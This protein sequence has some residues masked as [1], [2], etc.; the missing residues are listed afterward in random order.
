MDDNTEEHPTQEPQSN[1]EPSEEPEKKSGFKLNISG[2]KSAYKV[3]NGGWWEQVGCSFRK[4]I[5][6]NIVNKKMPV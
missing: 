3:C 4:E 5:Y 1:Q 6:L 2:L